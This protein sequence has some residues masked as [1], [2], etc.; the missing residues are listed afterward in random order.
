MDGLEMD[1][2]ELR[3]RILNAH[4]PIK[5]LFFTGK[6]N[7]LQFKDSCVA[8]SVMLQFAEHNQVALPI[9]DSF[10]MQEGFAGDL[11]AALRRAF[12]YA[13]EADI[14][15][16]REVIIE[17]IELFDEQGNPRVDAVTRDDRKHSQWCDRNTLWP[18]SR[19]RQ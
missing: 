11:E 5:A 13:Y 3:Q 2:R 7:M 10:M 15:I 8:E 4:K 1:W 19:G 9:H 6:G 16:K 18:H 12:Y 17:R 14:S